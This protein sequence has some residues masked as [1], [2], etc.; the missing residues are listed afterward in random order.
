M[1]FVRLVPRAHR[2][3]WPRGQRAALERL[4]RELAISTVSEHDV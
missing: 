2:F 3:D 1:A 4:E